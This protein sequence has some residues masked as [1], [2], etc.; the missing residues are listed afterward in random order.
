ML[1]SG[2]AVLWTFSLGN[3]YLLISKKSQYFSKTYNCIT[4]S[5]ELTTTSYP[6]PCK[7]IHIVQ[8]SKL[9]FCSR[10]SILCR[11]R[12]C[13]KLTCQVLPYLYWPKQ[14][15]VDSCVCGLPPYQILHDSLVNRH[16]TKFIKMSSLRTWC[17]FTFCTNTFFEYLY[18]FQD[19]I[20]SIH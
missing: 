11:L 5:K 2:C 19:F 14:C 16:Q 9:Q 18:Y 15:T 3:N 12:Y 20:I 13:S 6:V 7:S 17:Y 8:P 10:I 1:L 4:L